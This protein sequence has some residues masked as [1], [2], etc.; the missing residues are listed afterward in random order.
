MYY[1]QYYNVASAVHLVE[2]LLVPD[3][4]FINLIIIKLLYNTLIRY[5]N[6]SYYS[7]DE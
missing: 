2:L 1:L 7:N 6:N 3:I 5:I 4:I